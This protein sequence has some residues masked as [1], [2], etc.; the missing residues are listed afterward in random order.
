ML[1]YAHRAGMQGIVRTHGTVAENVK[2]LGQLDAEM[3]EV[4]WR[5]YASICTFVPQSVKLLGQL[6][7]ETVEVACVSG[8]APACVVL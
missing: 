4:V 8:A 5:R 2:L 7:A 1:P 3:A 6:D